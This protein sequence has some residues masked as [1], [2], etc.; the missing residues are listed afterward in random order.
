MSFRLSGRAEADLGELY[1]IGADA[2]GVSRADDYVA[3]LI[4][5]LEFIGDFP[6]AIRERPELAGS[7][8]VHTYVS[9]VILYEIEDGTVVIQRIRHGREDWMANPL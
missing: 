2:F 4:R 3:G 6:H 1:W 5:T 8:R 7:L 9:H